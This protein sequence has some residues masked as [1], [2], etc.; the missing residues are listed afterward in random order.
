MKNPKV[1]VGCPT[2]GGKAYI[3]QEY[4]NALKALDYDN[5]DI[6][7]IDNSPDER[8][9]A[10]LKVAGL[11]AEHISWIPR[12]MDRIIA[13]RNILRQRFLDGGYDYL[14]SVEQDVLVQP[15]T[16]KQLLSH[17]KDFVTTLVL[18]NAM[19]EGKRHVVPMVSVDFAN[20][21]GEL[22]YITGEDIKQGPLIPIK[23]SHLACTLLSRKVLERF[24]FRHD[25]E[26]FDD[27]CLSEDLLAAGFTLWCD[28][29][30]RPIHRPSDW[31]G[32]RK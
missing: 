27:T 18:N 5:F 14:L 13:A 7:L 2:W 12:A 1:L 28:T 22:R 4:A 8:Y 26:A 24:S 21:R 31:E 32:I 16:L 15:E 29:T 23:Q 25:D 30:L 19:I 11:P 20:R 17:K 9:F 10:L 6:L 3:L